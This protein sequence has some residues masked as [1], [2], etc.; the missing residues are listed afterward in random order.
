MEKQE[1]GRGQPGGIGK[2]PAGGTD[3]GRR[4]MARVQQICDHPLWQDSVRRIAL[5]ERDRIF[6]G[7]DVNHFLDVARLAYIENLER[8]MGVPKEWIYA[9]ALLHDIGRHLQYERG[10]PHDQGSAMLAEK[11]LTDCGFQEEAKRAVL[12][13]ISSHR[14]KETAAFGGL[15]GLIYRADKKSRACLFCAAQSDCDWSPEKK[16]MRIEV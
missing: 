10:I 11:I 9:A 14:K 5:L 15:S 7:H 1:S 2:A 13:A 8:G 4:E 16:N 3:R 12:E 6:C